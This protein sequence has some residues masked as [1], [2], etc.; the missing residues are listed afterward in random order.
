MLN[1]TDHQSFSLNDV[2]EQCAII[3]FSTEEIRSLGNTFRYKITRL[4]PN[5]RTE[6]N[7]IVSSLSRNTLKFV[8]YGDLII[9]AELKQGGFGCVYYGV[10]KKNKT[11]QF[12]AKCFNDFS[13]DLIDWGNFVHELVVHAKK[14]VH[15]DIK[16]ENVLLD[17]VNEKLTIKLAD[18]GLTNLVGKTKK[19][20]LLRGM[21]LS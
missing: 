10:F 6:G 21:H 3:H 19:Q 8:S 5:S 20:V 13:G 2:R 14:L 1:P 15:Q 12:A 17:Q 9:G 4:L 11:K 16:S 7:A 18:F